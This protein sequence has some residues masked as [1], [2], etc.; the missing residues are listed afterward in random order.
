[1]RPSLLDLDNKHIRSY[2][3]K[4]NLHAAILKDG[5]QDVPRLDCCNSAGRHVA[6]FLGQQ[7][8]NRIVP[9]IWPIILA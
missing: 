7:A 3:T 2:A 1:M 8:V 4:A 9:G 6:V 5:L